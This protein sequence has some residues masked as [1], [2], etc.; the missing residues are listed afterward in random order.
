MIRKYHNHKPQTTPW[1]LSISNDILS[2][3]IYDERDDFDSEI[4]NFPFLDGS[5]PRSTSFGVYI[6][7]LISFARASSHVVVVVS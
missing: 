5:V 1:H 4:V 2:T 3:K 6:S 7:Q